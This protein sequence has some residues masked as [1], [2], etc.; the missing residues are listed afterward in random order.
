MSSLIKK[1]SKV[2]KSI[3]AGMLT[4]IFEAMKELDDFPLSRRNV[5]SVL[6]SHYYE[7]GWS[8]EKTSRYFSSLQ[9]R[10]YLV[11]DNTHSAES[12]KFTDKAKLTL[13]EE[14]AASLSPDGAYRFVSFDIPETKRNQRDTFRRY[15]KKLGFFQIQ[16]SLWV[17]D[18]NIG[19][20]LQL[21]AYKC[22]IEEYM[23]YIVSSST[24][25]DGIL[26]AK[27][28]KKK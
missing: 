23:I 28:S 8:K 21:A 15:I 20:L 4:V 19:E 18:K 14:I 5:F 27:F 9:R 26:A 12:V 6:H 16:K 17:S 24:D 2:G 13:V 11:V 10:G 25:I 7:K 3:T 1:I 22:H